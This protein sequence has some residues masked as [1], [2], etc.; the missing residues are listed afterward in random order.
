NGQVEAADFRFKGRSAKSLRAEF[1]A[2]QSQVSV[3]NG[4]LEG[5]PRGRISFSGGAE[6]KN[7]AFTSPSPLP[8]DVVASQ[9]SIA[10]LQKLA[11]QTYPV[12]GILALKLSAH[13]TLNNPVGQG[14][15]TITDAQV[16]SEP[17]QSVALKVQGD[18]QAVIAN[19]LVRMDAGAAITDV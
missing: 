9:V 3:S 19:L 8:L 18:G 17:L 1:A 7:L 2:N 4:M 5:F 12:N 10:D 11:N 13:G 15:L 14:T 6:L 16:S